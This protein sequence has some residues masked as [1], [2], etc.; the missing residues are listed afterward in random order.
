MD[1]V[2]LPA[3]A[4]PHF[5]WLGQANC[6]PLERRG[7]LDPSLGWRRAPS[8]GSPSDWSLAQAGLP[9]VAQELITAKHGGGLSVGVASRAE[10]GAGRS[11]PQAVAQEGGLLPHS[12]GPKHK[13][14]ISKLA[15]L[16]GSDPWA[17]VWLVLLGISS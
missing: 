15:S 5:F 2:F 13:S 8:T 10:E 6:T 14:R 1:F 9:P 17:A 4:T 12:V 11:H 3:V 7:G 16:R